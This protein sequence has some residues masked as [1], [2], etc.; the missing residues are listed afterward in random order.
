MGIVGSSIRTSQLDDIVWML[1]SWMLMNWTMVLNR[2]ANVRTPERHVRT[3]LYFTCVSGPHPYPVVVPI[4][5]LQSNLVGH[6]W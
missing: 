5:R 6:D 3:Q 4:G 1:W 2:Y